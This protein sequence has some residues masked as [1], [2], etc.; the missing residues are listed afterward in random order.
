MQAD[1]LGL[2][3]AAVLREQTQEMRVVRRQRGGAGPEG[4]GQDP[5]PA[6]ALRIFPALFIVI[7][8]PGAIQ[9][10]DA[11][12]SLLTVTAGVGPPD[13]STA[14]TSVEGTEHA[15]C[16]AVHTARS[17][18]DRRRRRGLRP[19]AGRLINPPS[20]GTDRQVPAECAHDEQAVRRVYQD[21]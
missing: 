7:I 11:F 18:L 3:I 15:V 13:D 1:R 21:S 10:M 9:I 8:G 14:D 2:P 5:L 6:A 4:H 19:G 17:P 12:S 16:A 20:T